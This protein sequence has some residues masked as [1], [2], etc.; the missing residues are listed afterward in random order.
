MNQ[1]SLNSTVLKKIANSNH[2]AEVVMT[3]AAMRERLRPF[4]D[5][6]RTKNRLI[7][8]GERIIDEDYKKFWKDL[9]DAGVGVIVYGRKGNA[10]RFQWHY[11]MKKV[12]EAALE[13]RDVK[14]DKVPAPKAAKIEKPSKPVSKP[15]QTKEVAISLRP[16][17]FLDFSV[18]S[19]LTKG[20]VEMI[21]N[22][23]RRLA[24]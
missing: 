18:P 10:D 14:A 12:A 1:V 11:S 3:D 16:N 8:E 15:T 5:I 19:D 9:Q 13:G 4:S 21:A 22:T 24:A 17:F 7:R 23:L 20:E 6:Q 2:T